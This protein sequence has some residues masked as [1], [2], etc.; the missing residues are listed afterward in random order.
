M[1][2]TTGADGKPS[3]F[4][5]Q[6]KSFLIIL[7]RVLSIFLIKSSLLQALFLSLDKLILT[8]TE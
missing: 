1:S 3:K 2:V 5:F 8:L 4:S 7:L 6:F